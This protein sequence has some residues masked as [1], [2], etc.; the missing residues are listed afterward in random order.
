MKPF[1][2]MAKPHGP[3]CN[4]DCTYCYYLEKENLY[5]GSGRDFRMRDDVLE[6]YVSQYIHAYPLST[7]QF[8]WQGGEPTLLGIAFF[9]R[10][11][12]LQKKYA[13]GK[14]IENAFQTNGTLLDD[15]WGEF[16]ARHK[17]LIGISIDGRRK[18]T[19][20][21]ASTRVASRPLLVSCAASRS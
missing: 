20:P 3:I 14:T 17:F 10:V 13:N 6:K 16:L 1:H 4:L 9:E 21:I 7:V 15:A 11:I 18:F 2:I 12:D 8:A 5:S 19:M